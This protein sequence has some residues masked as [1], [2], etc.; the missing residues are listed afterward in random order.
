MAINSSPNFATNGDG[1]VTTA[2]GSTID[3]G[4]AVSIQTDGK[5]LVAGQS[6]N[7][8]NYDFA[9]V[10]YNNDGTLDSSFAGD[11]VTTTVTGA[12]HDQAYSVT[13]Q[14]DGKILAAGFSYIGNNYDFALV[15]YNMNGSLDSGF[16]GDGIVTTDIAQSYDI[17]YS[18]AVQSDGKILVAGYG[19]IGNNFDFCLV[20][21]NSNGSL[22]S[23]FDGDGKVITDFN[24]A[25]NYTHAVTTQSD[26]KILVAGYSWNGSNSDFALARYNSNGSLDSSF[27]GDGKV[28]TDLNGSTDIGYSVKVQTDGKILV[29]GLGANGSNAYFGLVRYNS[30]GSLD[31]SF[32]GDGKVITDLT[33]AN[34]GAYSVA[35]QSDGKILVAGYSF[36]GSSYDFCLIRYNSNGSLDTSFDGDGK[37]VTDFNAYDD[38][39]YSLAV[40]SDGKIVVVGVSRISTTNSAKSYVALAR[41]NSDGSLDKTFDATSTLNGIASYTENSSAVILDSTVEI[42]DFEMA[43]QGHYSGATLTLARH[44]SANAEDVFSG[45]GNLSFS[46]GNAVLSGITIATISNSNGILQLSFNANATQSRINEALSSLA[47]SNASDNPPASV[48]IDWLFNDNNAGAQGT[49]GALKALGSST[50]NITAVN[51]KP[52]L[53]TPASINYTDTAFDNSF[54]KILGTLIASDADNSTL[55]Y[56][57]TGGTDNGDGTISKT[58]TY[59]TLILNS[60]TGSYSFTAKDSAIEPLKTNTTTSITLTV[61]DGLLTDSK[62]LVI[63]ISQS[64][65][66]ESNSNDNLQGTAGNDLINGLSGNDVLNGGAGNDK[67]NGNA[68]NDTLTGG[69]GK[70]TFTFNNAVTTTNSDAI[71][72]FNPTDDTIKLE[73]GIFKS[74]TTTGILAVDKFVI[75]NA[76]SDG[77][78]YI[79][80]NTNTGGLFYDAD[81]SGTNASVQIAILGSNLTLTNADFAVI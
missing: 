41:Y 70:D 44:G 36:T 65:I 60:S 27:D 6:F 52:I 45:S 42:F 20:R 19:Y 47:Y 59:G 75:G 16:D 51:D 68:G 37:V 14:S 46:G 55:A 54:P 31:S 71:T 78:D 66:T 8:N 33:V 38:I 57:I 3:G 5:I 48:Q 7:G 73:N 32:D 67:L 77:N 53:T 50:V 15:R 10:R 63:N 30:N 26:G 18:V 22:D 58:I 72:D 81:G 62:S 74:L 43:K 79:I 23:S 13:I 12:Y 49:G 80:Y 76:A 64:G 11:G 24:L 17:G 4:Y 34:D 69:A 1:K 35:L 21:Y 40:Q 29:V 9:L 28:S 39:G 2:V 56:G 61:S 25:N